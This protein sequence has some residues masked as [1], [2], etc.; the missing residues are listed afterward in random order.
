MPKIEPYEVL[1][2]A[3]AIANKAF[4]LY[5]SR[6]QISLNDI[7]GLQ[8]A[9]LGHSLSPK[10]S[11]KSLKQT[12]IARHILADISRS[13]ILMSSTENAESILNIESHL[14]RLMAGPPTNEM[15]ANNEKYKTTNTHTRKKH[16]VD[17][18][19]EGAD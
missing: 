13:I 19:D 16:R 4:D 9:L 2:S 18:D 15:G 11:V 8:L 5:F 10:H 3:I 12:V 7:C 1:P 6:K 14:Q 17:F